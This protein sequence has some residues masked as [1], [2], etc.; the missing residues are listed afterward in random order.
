[1]ETRTFKLWTNKCIPWQRVCIWFNFFFD[2]VHFYF[3]CETEKETAHMLFWLAVVRD[4]FVTSCICD[5]FFFLWK[6]KTKVCRWNVVH[7]YTVY[8]KQTL[9]LLK[10]YSSVVLEVGLDTI[11]WSSRSQA[12][13]YLFFSLYQFGFYLNTDQDHNCGNITKLPLHCLIYLLT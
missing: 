13:L 2:Y 1:M 6:Q 12:D 8:P 11:F 9:R 4:W 7:H 3:N 10:I 5:F